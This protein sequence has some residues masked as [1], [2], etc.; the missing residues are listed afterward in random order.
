MVYAEH[1]QF[2]GSLPSPRFRPRGSTRS[3]V[4]IHLALKQR[5]EAQ[6]R[7]SERLLDDVGVYEGGNIG[8]VN[9]SLPTAKGRSV[10]LTGLSVGGKRLVRAGRSKYRRL[11]GRAAS[12][13]SS[14]RGRG[15]DPVATIHR[16]PVGEI[17]LTATWD[18]AT[19]A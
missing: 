18:S 7:G 16:S 14:L 4:F 9:D 10:S 2:N 13:S 19:S 12:G 17:R 5:E 15:V 6:G 3:S 11:G 1:S 8:T